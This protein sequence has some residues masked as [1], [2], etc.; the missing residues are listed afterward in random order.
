MS[1]ENKETVHEE[2]IRLARRLDELLRGG[3]VYFVHQ[4]LLKRMLDLMVLDF[5]LTD[6]TSDDDSDLDKDLDELLVP[7]RLSRYPALSE[8]V[9]MPTPNATPKL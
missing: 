4:N 8:S 6:V 9:I 3:D 5:M 2:C 1:T 7:P